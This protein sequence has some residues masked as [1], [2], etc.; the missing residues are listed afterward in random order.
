MIF[1]VGANFAGLLQVWGYSAE[2]PAWLKCDNSSVFSRSRLF[3]RLS[4]AQTEFEAAASL[5]PDMSLLTSIAGGQSALAIYDIGKL[6]LLYITRLASA[7]A[8]ETA[9]WKTRTSYETRT[10]AGGT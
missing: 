9:L 3:L 6:E 8:I 1:L 4:E 2:K 5:P 10:S 7:K